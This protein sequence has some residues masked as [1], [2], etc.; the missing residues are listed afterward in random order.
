MNITG[1]LEVDILEETWKELR[2]GLE[3]LE[4]L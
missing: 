3:Y 1:E 2:K 4:R